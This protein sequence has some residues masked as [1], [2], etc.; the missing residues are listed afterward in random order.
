MN[1]TTYFVDKNNVVHRALN[2]RVGGR[3]DF[4]LP[5]HTAMIEYSLG[6]TVI[7]H[8]D[9]KLY[10]DSDT[11]MCVVRLATGDVAAICVGAE[12][13][14]GTVPVLHYVILER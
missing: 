1:K 8:N 5:H 14:V 3:P 2:E 9:G 7:M 6:Y 13:L 4:V 10:S 11:P 12:V